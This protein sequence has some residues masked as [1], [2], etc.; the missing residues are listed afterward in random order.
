MEKIKVVLC[1]PNKK[2]RVAE[3]DN[4]LEGLQGA[5]QGNIESIDILGGAVAL[6]CNEEGKLNGMLPNRP[7]YSQWE[8]QI[9]MKYAEMAHEFRKAERN[10]HHVDGYIVFTKDSFTEP[11]SEKERTYLVSSYNKAFMPN[12]GGYSIYGSSLDGTD[13]MVRLDRYMQAEKGGEDGWKV[14]RCY[15]IEKK[16]ELVDLLY[17][18]FIIC[19]IKGE[20]YCSLTEGQIAQYL[21]EFELPYRLSVKNGQIVAMRF[22]PE[23]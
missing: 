1:E 12:M 17:G 21:E 7:A 22:D 8:E 13:L 19:G 4:T 10:G 14:E 16:K 11:Y 15:F 3:I 18:P 23:K 9:D 6:I 5:V 20:N 2:A